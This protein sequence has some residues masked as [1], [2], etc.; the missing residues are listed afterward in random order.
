MNQYVGIDMEEIR[1]FKKLWL[2]KKHLLHWFYLPAELKKIEEAAKPPEK[3]AGIWCAKE[4]VIKAFGPVVPL[5][6]LDIDLSF[7]QNAFP[8]ARVLHPDVEKLDLSLSVSISHT[9]NHAIANA[10]LTIKD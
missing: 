7:G 9:R 1:R 4:A 2:H 6:N 3:M 5:T 10:L 8:E